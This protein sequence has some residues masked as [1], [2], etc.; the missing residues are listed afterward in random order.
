MPSKLF[1]LSLLEQVFC[2]WVSPSCGLCRLWTNCGLD[3]VSLSSIFSNLYPALA[4]SCCRER[5]WA[6]VLLPL[7]TEDN[8]PEVSAGLQAQLRYTALIFR[9]LR[10]VQGIMYAWLVPQ[11]ARSL[12]ALNCDCYDL[13][14]QLLLCLVTSCVQLF[15]TSWTAA[16]QASLSLTCSNS[17]P[18]SW[19]CHP[20][21]SSSVARFCSCPQSFPASGSL[22][23]SR[24][25]A[26]SGQ[27]Y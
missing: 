15:A 11:A 2:H 8:Y 18:L 27:S 3:T 22:P 16:H 5:E 20:T 19:W 12:E 14:Y 26:S 17:C 9:S 1:F 4:H 23:M 13:S 25:F 7:K 21:I 10:R 6:H 24:L